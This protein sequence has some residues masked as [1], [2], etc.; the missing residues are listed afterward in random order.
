MVLINWKSYLDYNLIQEYST[1]E[2]APK[3]L[4]IN[5]IHYLRFGY[6][7]DYIIDTPIEYVI[8]GLEDWQNIT[9]EEIATLKKFSILSY[10][11]IYS[12]CMEVLRSNNIDEYPNLKNSIVEYINEII[13]DKSI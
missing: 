4:I 6:T 11:Q 5:I 2:A 9:K 12:I 1:Y 13:N 10:N 7:A 3:D 8:E